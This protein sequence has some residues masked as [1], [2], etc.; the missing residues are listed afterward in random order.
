[1]TRRERLKP[2]AAIGPLATVHATRAS[3]LESKAMEADAIEPLAVLSDAI[4]PSQSQGAP[5]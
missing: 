2:A 1:M 3:N 4:R 5:P